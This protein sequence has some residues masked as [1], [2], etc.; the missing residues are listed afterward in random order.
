MHS[1]TQQPATLDS[2]SDD[3]LLAGSEHQTTDNTTETQTNDQ[4]RQHTTPTPA[5]FCT[6][7]HGR[8]L[9]VGERF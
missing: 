7:K 5:D 2:S 4:E 8:I 3:H 9:F 6:K 1:H